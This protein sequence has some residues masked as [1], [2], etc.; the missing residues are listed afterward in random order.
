MQEVGQFEKASDAVRVDLIDAIQAVKKMEV[1]EDVGEKVSI[2]LPIVASD[3]DTVY[4]N[5]SVRR[6]VKSGEY[7]KEG[8]L[9]ASVTAGDKYQFTSGKLKIEWVD[10]E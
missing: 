7:F 4:R 8:R 1:G 3:D 2:A 6:R 5:T 9:S 10:R